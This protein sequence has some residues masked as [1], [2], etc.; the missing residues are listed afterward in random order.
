MPTFRDRPLQSDSED[1]EGQDAD[2]NSELSTDFD[3]KRL[4]KKL[5]VPLKFSRD[6]VMG[7][8]TPLCTNRRFDNALLL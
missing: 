5:R 4:L 3:T 6:S 1:E 2:M 7:A 8:W